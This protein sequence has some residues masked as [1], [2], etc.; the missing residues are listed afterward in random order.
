MGAGIRRLYGMLMEMGLHSV[1]AENGLI[2]FNAAMKHE[3]SW[4][5]MKSFHQD[6]AKDK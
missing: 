4:Q 6:L 3:I 1:D 2:S 5:F